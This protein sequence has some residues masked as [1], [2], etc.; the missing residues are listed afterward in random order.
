[1]NLTIANPIWREIAKNYYSC[2]DFYHLEHINF[3]SFSD[4]SCEWRTL[5]HMERMYKLSKLEV[6][7]GQMGK[8]INRL[9]WV[10]RLK[11]VLPYEHLCWS[12]GLVKCQVSPETIW[13]SLG[14]ICHAYDDVCGINRFCVN[15]NEDNFRLKEVGCIFVHFTDYHFT[16]TNFADEPKYIADHLPVI[17]CGYCYI[18]WLI[19]T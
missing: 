8:I 6:F 14:L 13:C 3:H 10:F 19:K 4:D 9:M 12:G 2:E 15:F 16:L 11:G 18:R 5:L 7:D 1:M 17:Y